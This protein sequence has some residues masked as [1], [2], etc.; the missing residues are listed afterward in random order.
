[1]EAQPPWTSWRHWLPVGVPVLAPVV[2][3]RRRAR[4]D[5][6]RG[7]NLR[8]LPRLTERPASRAASHTG[9]VPH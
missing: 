2:A 9:S 5:S 7:T 6:R 3:R 8:A 1:M 4:A